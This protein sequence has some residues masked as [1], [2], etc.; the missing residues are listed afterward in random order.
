MEKGIVFVI[1]TSGSFLL[2]FTSEMAR[3]FIG[4]FV[5]IASRLFG[6]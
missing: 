2:Y 5:N 6:L 4:F 3:S 1:L